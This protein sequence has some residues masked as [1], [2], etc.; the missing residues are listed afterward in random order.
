MAG[1]YG[2]ARRN[3]LDVAWRGR[4]LLRRVGGSDDMRLVLDHQLLLAPQFGRARMAGGGYPK[5]IWTARRVQAM[6][7]RCSASIP[8][9]QTIHAVTRTRS[10]PAVALERLTC[11][12][13]RGLRLSRVFVG[14][15]RSRSTRTSGPT[16]VRLV[17]RHVRC[18][19][20]RPVTELV[21]RPVRPSC[22]GAGL[23]R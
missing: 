7:G 23:C 16:D 12:G 11:A 20:P 2:V 22:L 13:V 3:A 9:Y 18:P 6:A 21:L 1:A 15:P 19:R 5:R 8:S 17:R 10:F 4:M 14:L